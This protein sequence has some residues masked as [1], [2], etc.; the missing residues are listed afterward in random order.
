MEIGLFEI[1]FF[2]SK[3]NLQKLKNKKT[4]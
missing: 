1:G 3:N 2:Y 4:L